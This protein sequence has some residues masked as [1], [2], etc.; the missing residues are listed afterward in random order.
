MQASLGI[1][2]L[3]RSLRIQAAGESI[4]ENHS[5]LLKGDRDRA[6]TGEAYSR[7]ERTQIADEN[8]FSCDPTWK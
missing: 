4:L 1:Y 2:R 3:H 8:N 5:E 6:T 7:I